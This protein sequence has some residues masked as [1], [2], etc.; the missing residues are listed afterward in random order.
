MRRVA[1]VVTI[2]TG[3]GAI[4]LEQGAEALHKAAAARCYS[5][6]C[7]LLGFG[8]SPLQY[9][10]HSVSYVRVRFSTNVRPSHT[11]LLSMAGRRLE[12]RACR[13]GMSAARATAI[14]TY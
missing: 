14:D 3:G 4:G 12:R 1:A 10:S 11:G 13:P 2:K 9:L 8:L 5:L 7:L 6:I